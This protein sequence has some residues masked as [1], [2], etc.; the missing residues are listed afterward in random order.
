MFWSIYGGFVMKTPKDSP[1]EAGQKVSLRGRDAKGVVEKITKD[2]WV[3]VE[4]EPNK[5]APLICHVNELAI[6][7]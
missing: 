7:Q 5:R 6:Q 1:T 3:W 4:W 2:G